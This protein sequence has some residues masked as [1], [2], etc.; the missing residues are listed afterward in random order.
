[1]FFP[2]TK[3]QTRLAP[4]TAHLT[5]NFNVQIIKDLMEP[6]YQCFHLQCSSADV[7]HS[8]AARERT[9]VIMRHV[10]TTDCLGDPIE[11]YYQI[12]E[13]LRSRLETEPKDYMIAT[14]EE[15]VLEAMAVARTR[16]ITYQQD[17]GNLEHLL[18]QRESD[19]LHYACKRYAEVYGQSASTNPNLAIF[20][21][22]NSNYSLTWSAKSGRIPTFRM[23]CG[24][25]YF[26]YF[27]RWMCHSEK[28][29]CFGF[30]IRSRL[31]TALGTPC[32]EIRDERRAAGL[33]GNTMVLPV[34]TLVTLVGLTC[35]ADKRSTGSAY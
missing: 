34:V 26:P 4:P 20:L 16:G 23:N 30:P 13:D 19:V 33:A 9:Y 12:S 15:V 18:T 2:Q 3:Q 7:G 28:M 10:A 27:G 17:L 5:Q 32:L 21:G 25:T 24:F 31:A 22:D 14:H 35:V 11:L 29:A 6:E 8:G 1:M